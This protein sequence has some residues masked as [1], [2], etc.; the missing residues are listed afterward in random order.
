MGSTCHSLAAGMVRDAVV[1]SLVEVIAGY[2]VSDV[3]ISME[4][5]ILVT[6]TRVRTR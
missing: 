2:L 5:G 6:S 1:G 3:G 4:H